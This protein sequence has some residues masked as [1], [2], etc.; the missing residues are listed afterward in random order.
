[1]DSSG[2]TVAQQR[3]TSYS[4][5]IQKSP[6]G[7]VHQLRLAA[8]LCP[9]GPGGGRPPRDAPLGSAS[10]PTSC[11]RVRVTEPAEEEETVR[12][13]RRPAGTSRPSLTLPSVLQRCPVPDVLT[14]E[15]EAASGP[16]R[17]HGFWLRFC[18][19]SKLKISCTGSCQQEVP[20]VKGEGGASRIRTVACP[21]KRAL[22]LCHSVVAFERGNHG[23][24]SATT[25]KTAE[26]REQ[27]RNRRQERSAVA[28][29]L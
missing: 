10:V 1:M 14:G 11:G 22:P 6:G 3:S 16:V 29:V 27:V 18:A 4:I 23:N 28:E 26:P 5:W 2:T 15:R 25:N 17:S 7:S 12:G 8:E 24:I 9:V 19:R 13:R 21:H 20:Q